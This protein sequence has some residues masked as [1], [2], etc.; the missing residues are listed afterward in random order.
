MSSGQRRALSISGLADRNFHLHLGILYHFTGQGTRSE[1]DLHH[2]V[3]LRRVR[4][5]DYVLPPTSEPNTAFLPFFARRLQPSRNKRL[6]D[7][8]P[9]LAPCRLA[10]PG[11]TASLRRWISITTQKHD[12]WNKIRHC[13]LLTGINVP[14]SPQ[15]V[16]SVS[17]S[18]RC[19][20]LV[21]ST[22]WL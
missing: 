22:T 14:K 12:E 21:R 1:S 19:K 13:S 4:A 10:S 15:F 8:E 3:P 16:E 20:M 17:V 6:L 9:P 7:S 5:T 18:L 11:M 2:A